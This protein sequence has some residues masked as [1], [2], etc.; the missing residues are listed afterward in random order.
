MDAVN[1]A[2]IALILAICVEMGKDAITDSKT[3]F[4]AIAGFAITLL[5]KKLNTAFVVL[6]GAVL[7]YILY[8]V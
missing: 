3:I 2:A 5:F 8:L 1:I 7:G 6:G 4:I